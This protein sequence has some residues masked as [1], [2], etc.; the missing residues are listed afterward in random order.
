MKQESR[1][2]ENYFTDKSEL[3]SVADNDF[4]NKNI[5]DLLSNAYAKSILE[6][7]KAS[8]KSTL[9]LCTESKISSSTGYRIIQKL[10]DNR[11]VERIYTINSAGRKMSLY[12]IRFEGTQCQ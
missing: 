4:N 1:F 7:I 12:K 5:Q 2:A 6:S 11:L 3:K 9:Q 10:Y 8:P